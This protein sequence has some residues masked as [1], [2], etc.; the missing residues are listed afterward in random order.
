MVNKYVLYFREYL[1][2][3]GFTMLKFVSK[4]CKG[5]GICVN[6]CPKKVLEITELE[7]SAI[8]KGK[9]D[10]CIECGQCEMRCP[11]YAIFVDKE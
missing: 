3:E 8:I 5:C 11:D 6:F 7:K 1:I 10:E 9:E 2:E 4:R